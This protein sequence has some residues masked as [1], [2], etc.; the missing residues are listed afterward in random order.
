MSFR[1][2]NIFPLLLGSICSLY[3]NN[4]PTVVFIFADDPLLSIWSEVEMFAFFPR[5]RPLPIEQDML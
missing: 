3:A 4:K 2:S 1:K 5:F